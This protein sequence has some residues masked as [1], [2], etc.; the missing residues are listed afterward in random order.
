MR[1]TIYLITLLAIIFFLW[2]HMLLYP[3]KLLVV[4]FHEASHALATIASGGQVKEMVVVSQQGGHVL[5]IGGNRFITLSAGYLG[6]LIWGTIIYIFAESSEN[7]RLSM[8]ILGVCVCLI[9]IAFVENAFGITFS[10]VAG[11]LMVAA[12][13]WLSNDINDFLLRLVG[14]TNMLYVPIDIYSD[15]I[16]RSHLRSDAR[17]LAEE[18]GGATQLWGGLWMLISFA[19]IA[20]SLRWS[21][22]RHKLNAQHNSN[23]ADP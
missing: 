4:F 22:K 11:M 2:D 14:L 12:A 20:T 17:M 5:S 23:Q 21:L 9:A 3:L 13:K 16:A 15:T 6:S 10:L 1:Q 7:D 8:F 18:F 19:V